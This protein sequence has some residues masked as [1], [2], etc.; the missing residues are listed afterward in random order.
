MDVTYGPL[1][2][3]PDYLLVKE[4]RNRGWGVRQGRTVA[5]PPAIR[6]FANSARAD[7]EPESEE[8]DLDRWLEVWSLITD[9]RAYSDLDEIAFR[10]LIDAVANLATL[11]QPPS[12]RVARQINAD[13][14]ASSQT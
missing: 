9:A 13:A 14:E 11:I 7:Q 10:S 3:L 1:S 8:T 2:G 5:I 12:A 6:A 4:M